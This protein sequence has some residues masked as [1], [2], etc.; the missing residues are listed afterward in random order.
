[1]SDK[2]TFEVE[3][4]SQPGHYQNDD[5]TVTVSHG[6][7]VRVYHKSGTDIEQLPKSSGYFLS[8]VKDVIQI[9]RDWQHAL[10]METRSNG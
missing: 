4:N 8:V 3:Y 2:I 5:I 6:A 9:G 10:K 7:D 1:M